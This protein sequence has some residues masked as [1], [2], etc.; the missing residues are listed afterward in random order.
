MLSILTGGSLLRWYRDKFGKI[1]KAEAC[2][3][4]MNVYDYLNST[5]ATEPTD[6]LVVSHFAGSGTPYMNPKAK[7]IIYGLTL[8]TD[9]SYIYRALMEEVTYGMRYNL[10]CLEEA[11]IR[12]EELRAVGGGTKADLWLQIKADIMNC[13]IKKLNVSGAGIIGSTI[14]SRKSFP[15]IPII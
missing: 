3:L 13:P 8:D 11:G 6:L 2:Q 14:F 9:S 5:A 4:G 12:I 7:G 15:C 1:A 10:E